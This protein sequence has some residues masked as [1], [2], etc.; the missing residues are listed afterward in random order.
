MDEKF[1]EKA[2]GLS[3]ISGRHVTEVKEY[4]DD[5]DN[6]TR[7]ILAKSF[8]GLFMD[9]MCDAFGL[10][11]NGTWSELAEVHGVINA[12]DGDFHANP[13]K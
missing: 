7:E 10:D 9:S 13:N 11:E 4:L 5:V 6:E 3:N 2:M 12:V 1:M 8:M